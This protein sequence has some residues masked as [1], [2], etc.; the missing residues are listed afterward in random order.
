MKEEYLE[1]L[2]VPHL[3]ISE[4][5]TAYSQFIT[6]NFADDYEPL[7]IEASRQYDQTKAIVDSRLAWEDKL[8]RAGY[9]LQIYNAYLEWELSRLNKEVR[10]RDM[11]LG[12]VRR[13][14]T[15]FPC[16]SSTWN[17][18]FRVFEKT[19]TLQE[20][21]ELNSMAI[22]A[23]PCNAE[24]WARLVRTTYRNDKSQDLRQLLSRASSVATLAASSENMMH[25][26]SAYVLTQRLSNVEDP[27]ATINA[28]EEAE[29]I[30]EHLN[31]VD[32]E[33]V[34]P[35]LRIASETALGRVDRARRVWKSMIKPHGHKAL[36]WLHYYQWEQCAGSENRHTRSLIKLGCF[37]VADAPQVIFDAALHFELY[38]GDCE[39]YEKMTAVV[40]K[41]GSAYLLRTHNERTLQTQSD[42]SAQVANTHKRKLD[43]SATATVDSKR[44]KTR[45]E[46]VEYQ[47]ES[48][49]R[50]G[51]T[52]IVHGLPLDSTND[53]IESVFS[54]V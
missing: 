7:M 28:V 15:A 40:Q 24:F 36:F 54:E 43:L 13:A 33:Y 20:L 21:L 49:N 53:T 32:H 3:N 41:A 26:L 6:T 22:R 51:T 35:R 4:T 39:E 45:S 18:A 42:T 10:T 5:F 19:T 48:R 1:R 38:Q 37:A 17:L 34:F 50:E 46:S 44:H 25:I 16:E 29:K 8:S 12:L 27:M 23:C 47:S 11:A 2:K 14:I 31:L 9:S 52:I 30:L